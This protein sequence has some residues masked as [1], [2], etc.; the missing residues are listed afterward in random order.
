MDTRIED[1]EKVVEMKLFE[2]PIVY[3][4]VTKRR[5]PDDDNT[6]RRNDAK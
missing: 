3:I 4:V 6:R 2:C 1:A 5:N